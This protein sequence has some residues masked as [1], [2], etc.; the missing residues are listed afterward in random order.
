M[1]LS[2]LILLHCIIMNSLIYESMR[3][4]KKYFSVTWKCSCAI[5]A[6]I[7]GTL[8]I[9]TVGSGLAKAIAGLAVGGLHTGACVLL[10]RLVLG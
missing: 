6:L 8:C 5:C 2:T 1:L 7:F 9:G 10:G 3:L 4:L